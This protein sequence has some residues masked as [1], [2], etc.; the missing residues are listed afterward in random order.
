MHKK[1]AGRSSKSQDYSSIV[2]SYQSEAIELDD[3]S[4]NKPIE[5]VEPKEEEKDEEFS[6][7]IKLIEDDESRIKTHI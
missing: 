4:T 2:S 5:K 1:V 7:T 3:A 6:D